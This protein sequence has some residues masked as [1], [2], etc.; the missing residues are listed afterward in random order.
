MPDQAKLTEWYRQFR[1]PIRSWFRKRLRSGAGMMD[2]DDLSQ[3]VYVRL[4][5]Y[6]S[7]QP[8]ENVQGYLYRIAANV[9]NE[10][11]ER[12]RYRKPHDDT[13]IDDLIETS[14]ELSEDNFWRQAKNEAVW[15][16]LDTLS[17][18]QRHVL[19]MHVIERLTYK[20]IA[21]KEGLTYRIVLR[22]LTKAYTALRF[23]LRDIK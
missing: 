6:P 19:E 20:Q 17:R 18:R 11:L 22:D 2:I 13:M 23:K 8:I 4:M 14:V 3:E 12:S 16:A 21:A 9:A 10:H 1:K 15:K 5:R 7:D